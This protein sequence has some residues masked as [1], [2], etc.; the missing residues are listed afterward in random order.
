MKKILFLLLFTIASYGQVPP[1]ATPLENVQI[2]NNSTST[3]AT[4]V[5][6]QENNGVLNT[7]APADLPIPYIPISYVPIAP[8]F[9]GH[10]IGIDNKL[11][12]I[13]ATT[14][15]QTTRVWFTADQTTI[16][17]GTFDLT[18]PTS[19]GT[20]PSHIQSVVNDDNQKKY[21]T[22]DVIG[23]AFI[24]DTMFPPGVYAGNLSASTTPNSAQQRWTVELYKCDNGGTPIASGVT[25]AVVGSLGVTVITILDSGLLTLA[26]GSVTNVQVSGNLGGTGFSIL[27]GERVRYHV[28]AEKVGT[29]ASNI[30][31]SVYYGTSYN[32]FIDVT[33]PLNTNGI[34]NGSLVTGATATDAL[35]NLKTSTDSKLN[36]TYISNYDVADNTSTISSSTFDAFGILVQSLTNKIFMFYREGTGHVTN[37][38]KIAMRSSTDGG[39]TFSSRTI[40][41][42]QSGVDCRNIAGGVTPSGRIVLFFLKVT[43]GVFTSQG[44]MYSDDDGVSWSTYTAQTTP[45]SNTGASPYGNMIAIANGRLA[46]PYYA[47]FAGGVASTYL[48]FSDDNGA[49]WGGDVVVGS[50]VT[51]GFNEASY[52]YLDGGV[53]LCVSRKEGTFQLLRQFISTDNG[54]TWTNQGDIPYPK[55]TNTAPWLNTY[56]ESNGEKYVSLFFTSKDMIPQ[57]TI[58]AI[59]ASKASV[60]AGVSGWLAETERIILTTPP[61]SDYGYTTVIN[62]R[63]GKKMLGMYFVAAADIPTTTANYSFFNYTPSAVVPAMAGTTNYLQKKTGSASLIDSQ[64]FDNGVSVAIGTATPNSAYKF[65]AE[66]ATGA[67]INA[68]SQNGAGVNRGSIFRALTTARAF[69]FAIFENS[70]GAPSSSLDGAYISARTSGMPIYVTTNSGGTEAKRATFHASGGVSIGN[71]T[72]LGAGTLNVTG[73]IST[74]A[75]TTA[76]QVVI[77]SQ[78]DAVRPYKVY[79]AVLTQ[80]GTSAPVATVLENTL[81]GTIVWSY[82]S[83]GIYDGTLT[84]AFNSAKTGVNFNIGEVTGTTSGRSGAFIN[85]INTVRIIT[86]NN[87]SAVNGDVNKATIEI[88]VYP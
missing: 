8:T 53:I 82:V 6:V 23:G 58:V 30:T 32:S 60:I 59:S 66:G 65:I 29:A 24:V 52:A 42:D 16:T 36:K 25:G 76:N 48:K 31:Q 3:T 11:N 64:F 71:T 7:M 87:G 14:A 54:Q 77:K 61:S 70:A 84:G 69:D 83:I 45:A 81:G 26:D 67:T 13:S 55:G 46:I 37:D 47:T 27:A 74:I 63:Q 10:I 18:N 62:P 35:N 56:I 75:A 38:G 19:K 41:H 78:L 79:Y 5:G 85:T 9:G 51:N 20:A 17:A 68:V 21:F 88:R 28:S 80:S 33:V 73:N 43:S 2:T 57:R 12:T 49:T 1:D 15:G 40:V 86:V 39:K 22:T 44:T 4:K 72:D 50:A 34:T